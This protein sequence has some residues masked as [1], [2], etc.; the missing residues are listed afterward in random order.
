M[1]MHVHKQTNSTLSPGSLKIR[2][3]CF[4]SCTKISL[5]LL[6]CSAEPNVAVQKLSV[7]FNKSC[8]FDESTNMSNGER[9][10]TM[11]ESKGSEYR[12][13]KQVRMHFLILSGSWQWAALET[14]LLAATG[15]WSLYY[16]HKAVYCTGAN[17]H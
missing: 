9:T 7:V 12:L 10:D 1:Y 11:S 17:M 16:K 5:S 4:P 6:G 14:L 13:W 15:L 3:E 2:S 8:F